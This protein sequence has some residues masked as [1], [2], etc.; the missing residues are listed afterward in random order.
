MQFA[1]HRLLDTADSTTVSLREGS[2]IQR[3]PHVERLRDVSDR[4]SGFDVDA[5]AGAFLGGLNNRVELAVGELR[6]AVG[7]LWVALGLCE[8]L[9]TLFDVGQTIVEQGEHV[10]CDFLAQSVSSAEIL[11]DPD[12][13]VIDSLSVSGDVDEHTLAVG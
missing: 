1:S 10:G 11:I 13:H 7:T 5:L 8:D 2:A 12:L 6:H 3:L 9:V 4:A